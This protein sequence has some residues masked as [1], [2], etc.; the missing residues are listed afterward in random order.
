MHTSNRFVRRNICVIATGILA[1]LGAGS[2][3][4]WEPTKTVEFIVPAG[5]G[6]GNLLKAGRV[7]ANQ[8]KALPCHCAW[9][10]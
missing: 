9:K 5:T 8:L 6:G 10:D 1:L 2:V 3:G 4:A 7:S